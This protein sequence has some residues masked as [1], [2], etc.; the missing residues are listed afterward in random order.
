M[1]VETKI[2]QRILFFPAKQTEQNDQKTNLPIEQSSTE[3][4][5]DISFLREKINDEKTLLSKCKN[6]KDEP[7]SIE[8]NH[9]GRRSPRKRRKMKF[10][11]E[12]Y[13]NT[14][15]PW[16]SQ[17]QDNRTID[18]CDKNRIERENQ[19]KVCSVS[20]RL[21][22][23]LTIRWSTEFGALNSEKFCLSK[24]FVSFEKF[25]LWRQRNL[26]VRKLFE[27]DEPRKKHW[28][29]YAEKN[30]SKKIKN[31]G[32][33]SRET[34]RLVDRFS[35]CFTWFSTKFY[36][37]V[38]QR[39]T[40]STKF[41]RENWTWPEI[42][43]ENRRRLVEFSRW[44]SANV[45]WKL[46]EDFS[47]D[48]FRSVRRSVGKDFLR[49][50]QNRDFHRREKS[51]RLDEIFHSATDCDIDRE[52]SN[53]YDTN[54]DPTNK[55][56]EIQRR[57]TDFDKNRVF[58]N[59]RPKSNDVQRKKSSK[60]WQWPRFKLESNICPVRFSFLQYDFII[61]FAFYPHNLD[62]QH[63]Q[64]NR[65]RK[66]NKKF[67]IFFFSFRFNEENSISHFEFRALVPVRRVSVELCCKSID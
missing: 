46:T 41:R 66:W 60:T 49:W 26:F 23:S 33:K 38:E 3:K 6:S 22:H 39:R 56:T 55:P 65:S 58:D 51:V 52:S 1:R 40:S 63:R 54:I 30:I 50:K 35:F 25:Y 47:P 32:V 19:P 20:N 43:D 4:R 53:F 57:S 62:R 11:Q 13:K 64:S 24:R 27:I 9:R 59:D 42:S 8:E 29:K 21:A 14:V 5:I 48:D 61:N 67:Y 12:I 10:R 34:I 18:K 31:C 2:S 15:E 28:K 44:N 36:G 7:S 37:F 45:R 16:L 17:L